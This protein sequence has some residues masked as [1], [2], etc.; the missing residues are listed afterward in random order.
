MAGR[1]LVVEPSDA[2]DQRQDDTFV[3][4]AVQAVD[5]RRAILELDLG[6]DLEVLLRQIG[7]KRIKSIFARLV[8]RGLQVGI[9]T[10]MDV[11]TERTNTN[12]DRFFFCVKLSIYT[13]PC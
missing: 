9:A 13:T 5:C 11:T 8:R 4:E 10:A 6:D 12:K 2:V 7:R 1:K 3:A